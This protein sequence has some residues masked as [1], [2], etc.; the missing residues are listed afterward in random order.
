MIGKL[1]QIGC[2][3]DH[4][5]EG[6]A[7]IDCLQVEHP[8]SPVGPCFLDIV[9]KKLLSRWIGR[10]VIIRG[11]HVVFYLIVQNGT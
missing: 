7:R 6:R 8:G 3:T 1:C 5:E 10:V 11:V 2:D 4:I 9:I